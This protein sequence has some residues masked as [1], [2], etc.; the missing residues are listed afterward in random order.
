MRGKRFGMGCSLA[1]WRCLINM[2]MCEWDKAGHG[3]PEDSFTKKL[4]CMVEDL[5]LR[6]EGANVKL[7]RVKTSSNGKERP[8]EAWK[9]L[10]HFQCLGSNAVEDCIS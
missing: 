9:T 8:W 7:E 3:A 4:I 1:L 6:I 5:V 2:L 10:K